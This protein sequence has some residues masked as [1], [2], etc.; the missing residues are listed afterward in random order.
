MFSSASYFGKKQDVPQLN[1]LTAG[2][3]S[4]AKTVIEGAA[5]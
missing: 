2:K 3:L 1:L 5:L 4:S